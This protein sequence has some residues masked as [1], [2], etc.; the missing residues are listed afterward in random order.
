M[1]KSRADPSPAVAYSAVLPFNSEVHA[2]ITSS[3]FQDGDSI[4]IG[5]ATWAG[6]AIGVHVFDGELHSFD[7]GAQSRPTRKVKRIGSTRACDN[8]LITIKTGRANGGAATR[9]SFFVQDKWIAVDAPLEGEVRMFAKVNLDGDSVLLLADRGSRLAEASVGTPSDSSSTLSVAASSSSRSPVP[10]ASPAPASVQPGCVQPGALTTRVVATG[11]Q[12]GSPQADG[13][14]TS[15]AVEVSDVPSVGEVARDEIGRF[16]TTTISVSSSATPAEGDPQLAATPSLPEDWVQFNTPEGWVQFNTPD[17]GV[18]APVPVVNQAPQAQL[19]AAAAPPALPPLPEGW[20][21]YNAPNGQIYNQRPDTTTWERPAPPPQHT[22]AEPEDEV[23]ARRRA[24][25]AMSDEERINLAM[26]ESLLVEARPAPRDEDDEMDDPLL[27]QAIEESLQMARAQQEAAMQQTQWIQQDTPSGAPVTSVTPSASALIPVQTPELANEGASSDAPLERTSSFVPSVVQLYSAE[28]L[29]AI[30]IQGSTDF[31]RACC[32]GAGGFGYVYRV[33]SGGLPSV[34]YQGMCAVKR[35]QH[36]VLQPEA[37]E[38]EIE[39]LALCHHESLLPLLAYCLD[40]GCRCLVYPYMPGGSLHDNLIRRERAGLL[41]RP[42]EWQVRLRVLVDVC[43]ALLYL[44]TPQGRKGTIFHRDIKPDNILL[45]ELRMSAKLSDFGL[46]LHKP[47]SFSG[48]PPTCGSGG[49]GPTH[50]S[51]TIVGTFGFLDPKYISG[52]GV[53]TV[54][55]DTYALG[56]TMLTTVVGKDAQ[57]SHQLHWPAL[58]AAVVPVAPSDQVDSA[59]LQANVDSSAGWHDDT[60]VSLV[61]MISGLIEGE[62]E[63]RMHLEEVVE[64]LIM[65]TQG[66]TVPSA[67]TREDRDECVVCMTRPRSVRFTCNHFCCCAHCAEEIVALQR[68]QRSAGGCPLCRKPVA[69]RIRDAPS[70]AP[71]FVGRRGHDIQVPELQ[72]PPPE[73]LPATTLAPGQELTLRF[74][75]D[76]IGLLGMSIRRLPV[77]SISAVAPGSMADDQGVAVGAIIVSVNGETNPTYD[78]VLELSRRRPL[79]LR[80]RAATPP[81]ASPTLRSTGRRLGALGRQ[82]SLSRMRRNRT[83]RT[84]PATVTEVALPDDTVSTVE[85]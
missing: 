7:N 17:Q 71:T 80:V 11:E 74:G 36:N 23:V 27:R 22:P 53:F 4:F 75:A 84:M 52:S 35:E 9:V 58:K 20:Q 60:I 46:G 59:A 24:L 54:H 70:S 79:E 68:T 3:R 8:S 18:P 5:V 37:L 69:I 76:D 48:R 41:S 19:Q 33:R 55:T 30:G 10:T 62:I 83:A 6:P 77:P 61:E 42:L 28:L 56:V 40:A 44:H 13:A 32:V 63:E 38:N 66:S 57:P 65:L 25:A 67:A 51:Q 78:R 64:Q 29:A 31:D 45:D 49:V 21:Q 16:Q 82:L 1:S 73:A 26:M 2:R 43:R 47:P 81:A 85:L 15:T 39:L 72:A 14:S 12:V 50:V 34:P